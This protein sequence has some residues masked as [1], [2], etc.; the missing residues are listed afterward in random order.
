MKSDVLVSV[1][2]PALPATVATVT[3]EAE[4]HVMSLTLAAVTSSPY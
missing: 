4:F 3:P 1:N 2:F